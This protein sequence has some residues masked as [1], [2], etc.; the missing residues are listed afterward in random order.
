[1]QTQEW[2]RF[3]NCGYRVAAVGGT[4]KMWAGMPVGGVRT[5]ADL[6]GEEFTFENWAGAIRAGRTFTTSGPMIGLTV[7]SKVVGDEIRLP[8]GGGTLGIEARAESVL[9]FH[10]LEA[11]VNGR[12]VASETCEPGAR[13]LSVK[14][15]VRLDGSAW[16]AARCVSQH[17]VWHGWPIHIAA[18]TSPV[19]VV[20]GDQAQFSL[21]DATYMMTMLDGG[22]TWLDTLSIPANLERQARIRG[23]FQQAKEALHQR[24]H[25]AG[26]DHSH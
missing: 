3:L 20:A 23:V 15:N 4:D 1:M 22:M 9:P 21:A 14:A 5:Y 10:T 18:H 16:L 19:Y 8:A 24:L 25:A 13:Q 2:Y 26:Y 6:R 11:V 12:V 7:E 17:Q